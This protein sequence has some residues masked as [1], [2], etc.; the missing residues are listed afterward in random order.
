MK[1]ASTLTISSMVC[2][3][4]VAALFTTG[5]VSAA[6]AANVLKNN[7]EPLMVE[8]KNTLDSQSAKNGDV[9]EAVLP[10]DYQ[11]NNTILPAGTRFKGT[12]SKS[13]E[14]KRF[15]RP[16]YVVLNVQEITLPSGENHQLALLEGMGSAET[17]KINNK[18]A[19]TLKRFITQSL[20]MQ[21][22]GM[23]TSIPLT[24]ATNMAGGLV[25]PIAL[26][27][28]MA[29]GAAVEVAKHEPGDDR[30]MTDKMAYGMWRGTGVP[31]SYEFM[32]TDKQA[33]FEVG[34]RM[35]LRL[36]ADAVEGIF[37]LKSLAKVTPEVTPVDAQQQDVKAAQPLPDVQPEQVKQADY[38]SVSP[39]T[40]VEAIQSSK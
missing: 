38:S 33:H 14:S 31:G 26:G 36:T 29:A 8:V 34:S 25:A 30:N 23:G 37:M 9:F 19:R 1:R 20:P 24:A 32:T 2:A 40:P 21:L 13:S 15:A 22:A 16:G 39:I 7:K 18:K 35:P 10:E 12:V 3:A 6:H 5:A 11:Y 28:R 27:A 4:V 17:K